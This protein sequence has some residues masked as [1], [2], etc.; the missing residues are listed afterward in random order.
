MGLG[1]NITDVSSDYKKKKAKAKKGQGKQ[2]EANYDIHIP[3]DDRKKEKKK[4]KENKG[5]KVPKEPKEP[6]DKTG[7]NL[8]EACAAV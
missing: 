6:K 5:P 2:I 4:N 7:K 3:D 1:F 8:S